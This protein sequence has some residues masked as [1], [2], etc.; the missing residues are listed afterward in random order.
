MGEDGRTL[1]LTRQRTSMAI[2][3]TIN[4]RLSIIQDFLA[5]YYLWHEQVLL[6]IFYVSEPTVAARQP[7]KFVEWLED[8]SLDA[9][10]VD[11]HYA[12]RRDRL[13]REHQNLIAK[14]QGLG[15]PPAKDDISGFE[16]DYR[17]FICA[18][19]EFAQAM[20]LEE[21][22]LDALTGLK[23]NA[24]MKKDLHLEMERL[25]REGA[26][27]CV[28]LARI[29]DFDKIEKKLSNEK[30]D[31]IIKAVAELVRRSLRTYDEAY[32]VSRD[33]FIMCLKQS[34]ISGGQKGMERLRDLLEEAEESYE[35]DGEKKLVSMS[36]CVA[37]PFP[38][39]DLKNLIA[40]LY[41]DLDEQIRDHGSVLTYQELSPLQRYMMN[42]KDK[43]A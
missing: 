42:D 27:F 25:S 7:A 4:N 40:N 41:I 34:D 11:G 23:N 28:G 13:I 14:A 3:Y 12:T 20:V 22:G 10:N 31:E 6:R 37:T 9:I 43:S 39:D 33:H 30:A 35:L 29:D 21:W 1:T 2:H 36:C 38:G 18:L 8:L 5:E 17:A 32:R 19:Q 16:K 24:V 15:T 26:P